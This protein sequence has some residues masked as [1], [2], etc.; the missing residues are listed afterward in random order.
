[1]TVNT[2]KPYSHIKFLGRCS[3]YSYP[4]D[5]PVYYLTGEL[6]ENARSD[7]HSILVIGP[8]G[9]VGR[10]VS[11]VVKNN[12]VDATIV[13]V[14]ENHEYLTTLDKGDA[15]HDIIAADDDYDYYYTE[16]LR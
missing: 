7:V 15:L 14:L 16:D 9:V 4:V 11:N 3:K 1:M 2:L 10:S 5:V 6:D 13:I 12:K 8:K